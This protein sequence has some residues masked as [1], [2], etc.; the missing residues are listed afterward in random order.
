MENGVYKVVELA[1]ASETSVED[2]V[3]TAIA[4]AGQSLHELGW[5]EVTETRG[6][7]DGNRVAEWQVVLKVGFTLDG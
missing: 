1:G 3:N 7:I 2:A 5:F 4:R 6:R